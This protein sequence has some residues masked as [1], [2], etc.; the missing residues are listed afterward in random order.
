M[1]LLKK[2]LIILF[3]ILLIGSWILLMGFIDHKNGE[4]RLKSVEISIQRQGNILITEEDVMDIIGNGNQQLIGKS[5]AEINLEDME[6]RLKND[7][8]VA[9]ANVYSRIPGSLYIEINQ[10]APLVRIVNQQYEHFYI[11]TDGH[12]MALHPDVVIPAIL[13]T[14]MIPDSLDPNIVLRKIS[15][16]P[17]EEISQVSPLEIIYNLALSIQANEFLKAQIEQIYINEML[18]AEMIPKVGNHLIVFGDLTNMQGKLYKLIAFY[19][20]GIRYS[21]WDIYQT[22]NLKYKNQ[23]VCTK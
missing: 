10:R 18:Q 5:F 14:G 8:Y 6:N 16:I 19:K 23:V 15:C 21:G 1:K 17:A 3:W 12:L 22:I 4:L 13:A 2:I 20:K 9:D 7:G 11:S